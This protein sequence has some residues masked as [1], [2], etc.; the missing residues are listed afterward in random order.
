MQ[1]PGN[2][3]E[4]LSKKIESS[5]PALLSEAMVQAVVN[6]ILEGYTREYAAWIAG[7]TY[8]TFKRYVAMGEK[9]HTRYQYF[10]N[11]LIAAEQTAINKRAQVVR[12]VTQ[13]REKDAAY[14]RELARRKLEEADAQGEITPALALQIAQF[15]ANEEANLLGVGVQKREISTKSKISGTVGVEP[16]SLEDIIRQRREQRL[17]DQAIEGTLVQSAQ[18][19]L[20]VN[21]GDDPAE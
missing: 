4:H 19:D 16:V 5:D 3:D 9:G 6:A 10:Y 8:E 1:Q 11:S 2:H 13:A 18:D 14:Y 20:G 21:S 12:E 7:L 17:R 15:A